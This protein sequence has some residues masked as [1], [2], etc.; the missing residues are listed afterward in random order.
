MNAIDEVNVDDA[1]SKKFVPQ[2]MERGKKVA[3]EVSATSVGQLVLKQS[4]N[5]LW[6]TEKTAKWSC[7]PEPRG[8]SKKKSS[9]I[10]F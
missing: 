4:D 3:V 1:Q 7:P 10:P 9:Q 5:L 6:I 8:L 2:L